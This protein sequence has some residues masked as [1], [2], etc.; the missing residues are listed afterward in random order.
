VEA[1]TGWSLLFGLGLWSHVLWSFE[2]SWGKGDLEDL[3]AAK[4]SCLLL[5]G[6]AQ[7]MLYRGTAVSPWLARLQQLHHL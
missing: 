4:S 5:V 2:D 6:N 3:G 1:H 7:E